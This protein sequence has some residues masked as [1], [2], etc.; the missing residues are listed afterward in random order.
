MEK[1]SHAHPHPNCPACE[2]IGR[3]AAEE[4]NRRKLEA[5]EGM[6][7]ALK[8]LHE[9]ADWYIPTEDEDTDA[10]A[11]NAVYNATLDALLAWEKAGKGEG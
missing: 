2:Q 7:M 3:W 5:A 4:I 11:I 8:A 10:D 6:A 9:F 1:L